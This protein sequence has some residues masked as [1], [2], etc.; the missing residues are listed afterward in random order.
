MPASSP[1]A[2]ADVDESY[3]TYFAIRAT[4]ISVLSVT[5]AL[6]IGFSMAMILRARERETANQQLRRE[7]LERKEIEREEERLIAELK[8]ALDNVKTLR[9]LL[10]ICS[11]CK[12]IRDDRGL[13]N[14]IEGY[15]AEHSEAELSHGICPTCLKE[16]DPEL[17]EQ[18]R[19]EGAFDEDFESSE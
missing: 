8:Q 7:I 10:P 9:G 4:I 16:L 13:W 12:K 1:R 15:I 18:M 2:V 3:E 14:R 6:F 19:Q 17:W 11:T 5:A